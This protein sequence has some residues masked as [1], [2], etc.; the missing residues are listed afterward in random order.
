MNWHYKSYDEFFALVRAQGDHV[1]SDYEDEIKYEIMTVDLVQALSHANDPLFMWIEDILAT[2]K[3]R[4]VRIFPKREWMYVRVETMLLD[5]NAGW[6]GPYQ[7]VALWNCWNELKGWTFIVEGEKKSFVPDE[8]WVK[9]NSI[10]RQKRDTL[11]IEREGG[12][13]R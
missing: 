8:L 5:E 1:C 13:A 11:R 9:E 6:R 7:F 2:G 10:M 4:E 12:A 3:L